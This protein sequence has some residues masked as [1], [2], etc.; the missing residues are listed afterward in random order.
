[1]MR[2]VFFR[3]HLAT[4]VSSINLDLL[5]GPAHN[6]RDKLNMT[7]NVRLK[8]KLPEGA[9]LLEPRILWPG[10]DGDLTGHGNR[11]SSQ[12]TDLMP[13]KEKASLTL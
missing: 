12:N 5:P 11:I 4:D 9:K 1:M 3:S 2:K 6:A 13:V 8:H 7:L 10:T